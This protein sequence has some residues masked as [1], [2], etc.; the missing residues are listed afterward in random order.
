MIEGK[1][2]VRGQSDGCLGWREV[3]GGAGGETLERSVE[4]RTGQI[5]R[6]HV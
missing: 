3:V 6:A 4:V 5:G 2:R 1:R